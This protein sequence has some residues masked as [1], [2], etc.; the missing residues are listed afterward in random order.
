MGDGIGGV[1]Q[2]VGGLDAIE[3]IDRDGEESCGDDDVHRNRKFQQSRG[4]HDERGLV[5]PR[6]QREM[7]QHR[8]GSPRTMHICIIE[9]RAGAAL[10]RMFSM[11]LTRQE[12]DRLA[13][14][15]AAQGGGP[16]IDRDRPCAGCGYNVRGLKISGV[17]PECGLPIRSTSNI[18]D[19]LSSMPLEVIR[20]FRLGSWAASA[21]VIAMAAVMMV[22]GVGGWLMLEFKLALIGIAGAW[23]VSVF[24]LTP[25]LTQRQATVRGFT[26]RSRLRTAARWLQP[27]WIVAAV[28][29]A[30]AFAIPAA[31]ATAVSMLNTLTTA[32]VLAGLAGFVTVGILLERLSEW[33]RDAFAEKCFNWAIWFIPITT[34]G[35][36]IDAMFGGMGLGVVRIGCIF[37]IF[38]L[39]CLLAFPVGVL[40]LSR[41]VSYAAVHAHERMD[42]EKRKFK[43]DQSWK[44]SVADR[45]Q[46]G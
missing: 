20:K 1:E 35:L 31:Q 46:G 45:S 5:Q 24:L 39:I 9:R 30:L 17:C 6:P 40:S 29:S 12:A 18:D 38:W 23:V 42:R 2:R 10:D 27:G 3:E 32:G 41:S 25:S 11:S 37:I 28:A 16:E 13:A 19:P 4:D 14:K 22:S 7:A 44:D 43:R 36:F 8:N 15:V 33:V 21:C 34:G 26:S